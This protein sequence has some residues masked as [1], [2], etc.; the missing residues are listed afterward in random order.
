M[1]HRATVSQ[2]CNCEPYFNACLT[3]AFNNCV[4]SKVV[5]ISNTA[6]VNA[7]QKREENVSY[8]CVSRYYSG[9][10][11]YHYSS[12]H[13]ERESQLLRGSEGGKNVH[14]MY[15]QGVCTTDIFYTVF[16]PFAHSTVLA[17]FYEIIAA[18]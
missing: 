11:R 6:A 10:A 4:T 13:T 7:Q 12:P 17:L 5:S 14:D 8:L 3:N 18:H 9:G 1:F 15:R 2:L 16:H